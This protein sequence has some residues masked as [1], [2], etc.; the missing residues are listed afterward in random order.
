MST[1][2]VMHRE[3]SRSGGV[4]ALASVLGMGVEVGTADSPAF[5]RLLLGEEDIEAFESLSGLPFGLDDRAALFAWFVAKRD[6]VELIPLCGPK[7]LEYAYRAAG[8]PAHGF[9]P[10]Y[11]QVVYRTL[12]RTGRVSY[13]RVPM[14]YRRE[15]NWED[16]APILVD[17][18]LTCV[19]CA[20]VDGFV[21]A[22]WVAL[23]KYLGVPCYQVEGTRTVDPIEGCVWVSNTETGYSPLFES[24]PSAKVVRPHDKL[25]LVERFVQSHPFGSLPEW[26][27]KELSD[28]HVLAY[29]PTMRPEEFE[30]LLRTH[31]P[32][33]TLQRIQLQEHIRVKLPVDLL[34]LL[35]V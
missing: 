17:A 30:C 19:V 31:G 20:D 33:T 35:K 27:D 10:Y 4:R 12:S 3:F 7:S 25:A 9:F 11:G 26:A 24:V 15:T 23:T 2:I 1:V 18:P 29:V 14:A 21:W 6:P 5:D 13:F 28:T 32:E 8:M 22:E 16:A 34:P